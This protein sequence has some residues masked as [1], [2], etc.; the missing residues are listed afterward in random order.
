MVCDGLHSAQHEDP[1]W[2]AS[3]SLDHVGRHCAV[4]AAGLVEPARPTSSARPSPAPPST[5]RGSGS[6]AAATPSQVPRPR[7]GRWSTSPGSTDGRSGR[8]TGTPRAGRAGPPARGRSGA[9][10]RARRDAAS[11]A[12]N[13]ALA[14]RGL[15]LE[16]LGD[17]D[18]QTVAGALG[19]GT[20]GTG[21]RFTGLA[22]QVRG[23]RVM[24][25]AGE[26]LETSAESSRRP[27]RGRAARPG[28]GRGGARRDSC[29]VPA[30]RLTAREEP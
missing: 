18:R 6:W 9:R 7:R 26:V 16:N 14:R 10:H 22:A 11:V 3:R 28:R 19:T 25:A 1:A 21:V 17:I 12:L 2:Q 27:L 20:H 15:A 23:V 8:P 13:L 4:P 30:F 24:T 29:A 5:A